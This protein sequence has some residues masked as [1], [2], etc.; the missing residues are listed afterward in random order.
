MIMHR[1]SLKFR[2]LMFICNPTQYL[3][4]L[5]DF[6]TEHARVGTNTTDYIRVTFRKP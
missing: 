5:F 3:P 1:Q 6:W 2:A 4:P